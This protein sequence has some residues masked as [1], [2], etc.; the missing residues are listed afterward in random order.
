MTL[1]DGV[2]VFECHEC[3]HDV[4]QAF[5]AGEAL[6][7]ASDTW[8]AWADVSTASDEDGGSDG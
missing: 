5:G 7:E 2:R 6:F 8:R 4:G 1:P 3:G